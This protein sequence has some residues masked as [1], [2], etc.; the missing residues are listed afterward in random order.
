MI[1]V[2]S[3]PQDLH[4]TPVVAE[5]E[6]RG[7]ES[8]VFDLSAYPGASTLTV[9]SSA[10]GTRA[11]LSWG[12]SD[13]D[14]NTVSSVWYRR[15]GRFSLPQNLEPGESEWLRAECNHL[16]RGLWN[17][18]QA[19]WV[20]APDAVRRA[21]LKLLQ[22][23]L[24]AAL[25]F[26]LPRFTVTNSPDRAAAFIGSCTDGAIVKVLSSPLVRYPERAA[27]LY[28]HLITD[29]DHEVID[30][31]R[32][33]P[34]FL[35]EFVRK[36]MDVRVTVIGEQLFAVGIKP[37]SDAARVDFRRAEIYDLPHVSIDLPPALQVRSL[38]LVKSLGLRF[39]AIDLLLTPD[40][41]Y[42]F[43]EINPNGQ[44]YWL[45]WVTGIPLTSAMCDLLLTEK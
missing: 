16:F 25:G 14:L 24:A 35:Q 39:G 7:V 31:V 1:L 17:T 12:G 28:T 27:T 21:G 40:G 26:V 43:L 45:E 42:V 5:L 11:S 9:D 18:L 23:D 6:R 4:V 13:L 36:A 33:G 19:R 44:W 38:K 30:S 41:E 32:F 15:P 10:S 8:R 37:I 34:T 2:L 3:S 29:Q 20:S 22:L